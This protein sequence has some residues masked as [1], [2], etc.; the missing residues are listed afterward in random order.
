LRILKPAEY[1]KKNWKKQKKYFEGALPR[2]VETYS[3]LAGRILEGMIYGLPDFYWEKEARVM[4]KITQ[5]EINR[6]IP[7]YLY[8]EKLMGVVITDTTKVKLKVD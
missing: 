5:K 2:R 8:P 6:I 4:Q 1:R 7:E 3:G